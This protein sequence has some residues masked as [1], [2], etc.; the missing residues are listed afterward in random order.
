LQ[1]CLTAFIRMPMRDDVA[2]EVDA[3][4]AA[5]IAIELDSRV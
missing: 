3:V 2:L 1:F 5:P 4:I